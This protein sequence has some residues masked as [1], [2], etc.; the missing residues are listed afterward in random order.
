MFSLFIVFVC[1]VFI[2]A[3]H[4]CSVGHILF[5]SIVFIV[6]IALVLVYHACNIKISFFFVFAIIYFN[7]FQYLIY[8]N[9]LWDIAIIVIRAQS[10][11]LH[12]Y[13]YITTN[14]AKNV[15]TKFSF[16]SKQEGIKI[17]LPRSCNQ[18]PL[19]NYDIQS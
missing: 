13:D 2:R 19:P 12:S 1:I 8:F 9:T 4:S 3:L 7:Q 17:R 14:S 11:G 10:D 15:T 16:S 6:A 5:I 18:K